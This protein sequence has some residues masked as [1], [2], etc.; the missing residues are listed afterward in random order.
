MASKYLSGLQE[1][2]ASG[3]TSSTFPNRD[4]AK[5]TTS[6]TIRTPEQPWSG[7]PCRPSRR[8]GRIRV[9]DV[10]PRPPPRGKSAPATPRRSSGGGSL[11]PPHPP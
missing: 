5:R 4:R 7:R 9:P 3:F 1:R 6:L 2:K 8:P 10:F 11:P